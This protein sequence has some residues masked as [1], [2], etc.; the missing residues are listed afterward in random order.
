MKTYQN[1]ND[2]GI[3]Y[4]TFRCTTNVEFNDIIKKFINKY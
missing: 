2:Y 3:R 4:S 1:Y